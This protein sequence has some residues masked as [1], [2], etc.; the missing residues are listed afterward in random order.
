MDC[1]DNNI[2]EPPKPDFEELA[3]MMF[4]N[5]NKIDAGKGKQIKNFSPLITNRIDGRRIKDN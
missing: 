5:I 1:I 2:S 3:D 4:D